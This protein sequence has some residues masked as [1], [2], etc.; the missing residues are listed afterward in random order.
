MET[1]DQPNSPA[2]P[3]FIAV[4][5]LLCGI[6]AADELHVCQPGLLKVGIAKVIENRACEHGARYKDLVNE[7][8]FLEEKRLR[9]LKDARRATGHHHHAVAKGIAPLLDKMKTTS[10]KKVKEWNE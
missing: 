3:V 5:Q 7:D 2:G 9:T 10:K 8:A 1:S 4:L 6:V